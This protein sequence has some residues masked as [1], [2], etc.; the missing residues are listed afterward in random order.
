MPSSSSSDPSPADPSRPGSA[1]E[2]RPGRH[3]PQQ[4]SAAENLAAG[5]YV[6]STPIG[7][8]RDITLRA[9]DVLGLADEVLAE[10]TRQTRKLLD[11]HGISAKLSPYHDHNGAERRPAL[12]AALKEGARIALV[13]DAGTPLVSDPGFKLVRD[14]AAAGVRIVPVPGASAPLA[15]LVLSGLPS[16]RFMFAGFPPAKDQARENWLGE[17]RGI[18]ATLILFET[19]PRLA[20]SLSAMAGVFGAARQAVVARELTK[21]F[22]EARHGTLGELAAAYAS[23]AAPK[24]EIVVVVGPPV[25]EAVTGEALDAALIEAMSRMPVKAAAAEVAG[26]FG[27]ARRTAYQRALA[28]KDGGE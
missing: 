28:L 14:A 10:D 24:G 13:S 9:L 23:E 6:V 17:L 5:L 12:L 7:N 18:P 16:D 19:G 4:A 26:R 3:V 1:P 8:L 21:L 22:E 15:A 27:L 11:A 2:T 25:P 20:A